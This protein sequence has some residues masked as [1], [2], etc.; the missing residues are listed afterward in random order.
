M[1]TFDKEA[2][3]PTKTLIV[4]ETM[5][6]KDYSRYNWGYFDA[7]ARQKRHETVF[8]DELQRAFQLGAEMVSQPW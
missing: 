8:P 7:E 5:Q 2:V 1:R 3:G 4:G 6:V